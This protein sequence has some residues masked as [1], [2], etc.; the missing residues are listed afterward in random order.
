VTA[1]PGTVELDRA[2]SNRYRHEITFSTLYV[3]FDDTLILNGK[4]NTEVVKLIYQCINRGVPVKLLT[5]HAG[6]LAE[7]L[8]RYR[9]QGLFDE[10]IHLRSGERKSDYIAETD[11]ILLDDSYAER[12]EVAKRRGI[13]TFD[14]SMIE[15]LTLQAEDGLPA[16]TR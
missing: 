7:A 5:R 14:C 12:M 13:P 15:L 11:A 16:Q 2:L 10:V 4:V 8:G 1:N 9:L 6:D 3:D